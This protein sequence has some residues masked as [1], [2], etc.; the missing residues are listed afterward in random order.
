[1][2]EREFEE[3]NEN[4]RKI[5]KANLNDDYIRGV[6]LSALPDIKRY[7]DLLNPDGMYFRTTSNTPSDEAY[8][9]LIAPE[10]QSKDGAVTRGRL[11]KTAISIFA[12]SFQMLTVKEAL[13]M[14]GYEGSLKEDYEEK[15]VGQLDENE[16]GLL[17]ALYRQKLLDESVPD[18]LKERKEQRS[19][20][21]ES[22]FG[23]EKEEAKDPFE[24]PGL[25]QAA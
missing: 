21:L 7:G 14:T 24:M 17:F 3:P 9:Q 19:K 20:G 1:M 12:G 18:V 25:A 8:Q 6:A 10:L 13:E 11:E 15:Y 22:K 5:A 2:V 23:P 4:Q 16:S